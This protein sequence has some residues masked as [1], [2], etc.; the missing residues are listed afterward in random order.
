MKKE[1]EEIKIKEYKSEA[2]FINNLANTLEDSIFKQM[3]EVN[4][5]DFKELMTK[6][7]KEFSTRYP[8]KPK[9]KLVNLKGDNYE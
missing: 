6:L 7:G 4:P 8:E 3:H 1:N 5:E 9:S 2:E